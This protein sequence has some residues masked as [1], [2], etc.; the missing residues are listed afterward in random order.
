MAPE[1]LGIGEDEFEAIRKHAERDYPRLACGVIMLRGA[2]RRLLHCRNVQ[3]ELHTRDPKRYPRDGRTAWYIDP[4]DLLRIGDLE[5]QKFSIG[6]IYHS[7]TDTG[8]N[9]SAT[10]KRE[11]LI[12]G[13]PAF[14]SAAYLVLSVV[15]GQYNASEAVRWD[16][17]KRDFVGVP[18]VPVGFSGAPQNPTH[19]REGSA[20]PSV[21]AHLQSSPL[22]RRVPAAV[23][24]RLRVSLCHSS[25]DKPAVRVLHQRLKADGFDPW[26]D[27][28]DLVPGQDWQREI[29]R[30]V[31]AADVVLVCLSH[32]ATTKAGFLQREIRYALD[33]AEEQP[34]GSIFL[35]PAKLGDCEVPDRLT[36]WQWVE[37]HQPKGYERLVRALELRRQSLGLK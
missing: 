11:A 17:N 7:N 33:V 9:F 30:A 28:E 8:P 6:V 13:E 5:R 19:V 10:D 32:T 15:R 2:E 27:E 34:E 36:R 4:K 37:L 21:T 12:G 18:V 16:T 35:I 1:P 22:T 25:Q 29:P 23:A 14:P 26:L 20:P 31:R 3:D 24:R